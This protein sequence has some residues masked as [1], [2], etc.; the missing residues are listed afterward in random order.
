LK[1]IFS[2]LF[3]ISFIAPTRAQTSYKKDSCLVDKNL[4]VHAYIVGEWDTVSNG[5]NVKAIK[6]ELI[7]NGMELMLTDTS[8]KVISY[9]TEFVIDDPLLIVT[10]ANMG[11]K[12]QLLPP[13]AGYLEKL[14]PN[15]VILLSWIR[16]SKH[17]RCYL[18][19]NSVY[20][21]TR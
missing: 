7:K 3:T 4:P 8:Y 21:L 10:A 20:I 6:R 13:Y 11:S 15:E 16:V 9:S 12:L 17:N 19:P 2:I 18:I 5:I 14:K 1:A